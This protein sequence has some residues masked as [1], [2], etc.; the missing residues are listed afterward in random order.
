MASRPFNDQKHRA[1]VSLALPLE[2]KTGPN[3]IP[4]QAGHKIAESHVDYLN[5]PSSG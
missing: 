2:E 3:R 4:H 1:D 5:A